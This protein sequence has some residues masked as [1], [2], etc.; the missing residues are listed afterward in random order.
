MKP[1]VAAFHLEA[2]APDPAKRTIAGGISVG[3]P[4]RLGHVLRV[5]R[6]SGGGAVAVADSEIKDWQALLARTEGVFCE[7]TSSAA[8]A[9]LAKLVKSGVINRNEVVLVPITGS[10]LK[11][12]LSA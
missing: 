1:I 10:G 2:W 8:F 4:P 12:P 3:A 6:E 5:L 9:G 7:P 11:D